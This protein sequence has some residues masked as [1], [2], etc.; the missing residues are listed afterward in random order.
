MALHLVAQRLLFLENAAW[1]HIKVVMLSANGRE[2]EVAKG[3]N[4]GADLYLTK[5]FSTREL[6]LRIAEMLDAGSPHAA[7]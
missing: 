3:L 5:P 4:M 1:R 2:A 6:M 7:T